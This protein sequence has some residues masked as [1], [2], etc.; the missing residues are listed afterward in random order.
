[1][2]NILCIE[3]AT[4]TLSVAFGIDGKTVALKEIN[5][6]NIHAE[7]I[8]LFID[9]VLKKAGLDFQDVDAVAVSKGPGSYTGLRIGV[10]AAKGVC[11]AM[12]KPL[13][14]VSTLEQMAWGMVHNSQNI[15]EKAL[16]IPMIDARRMEVYDA[17]YDQQLHLIREVQP[18]I[19]DENSFSEYAG[20][21]KLF[22]GGN[23]AKKCQRI[24]SDKRFDYSNPG[25]LSAGNMVP[26]AEKAFQQ[27][28]FED[29]AYFEP[30]Y[31]KAFVAGKPKVKGLYD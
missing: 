18:H 6:P 8:T 7:K 4:S 9:E 22:L 24:L 26:L 29:V 11:Y 16:V 19:I 30:F 12:D 20:Y 17:V 2:A 31:L 25:N 5:Q 14:A 15:P 21:D 1:M 23:G 3:T 10:S 13:I 28:Q 27:K